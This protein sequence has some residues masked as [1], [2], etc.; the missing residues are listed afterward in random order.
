MNPICG[1][2]ANI[3]CV[4][5][6]HG[7]VGIEC[8]M[9]QRLSVA[10]LGLKAGGAEDCGVRAPPVLAVLA[11]RR[12]R[13]VAQQAAN[14]GDQVEGGAD[15]A[16]ILFLRCK[17]WK[18]LEVYKKVVYGE[19]CMYNHL[20]QCELISSPPTKCTSFLHYYS[21]TNSHRFYSYSTFKCDVMIDSRIWQFNNWTGKIVT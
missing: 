11:L 18:P 3:V 16:F 15:V 20:K 7:C 6:V 17:Q 1:S 10:L 8:Q 9:Q 21:N 2:L 14:D 13:G 5:V 4:K 19:L 12:V